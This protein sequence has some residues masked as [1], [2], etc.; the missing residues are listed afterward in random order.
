MTRKPRDPELE[1][2]LLIARLRK[3]SRAA[4]ARDHELAHPSKVSAR[5][6]SI[7]VTRDGLRLLRAWGALPQAERDDFLQSVEVASLRHRVPAPDRPARPS[8]RPE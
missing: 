4:L 5:R 7:Q 8:A 3:Q 2:L 1:T 6:E